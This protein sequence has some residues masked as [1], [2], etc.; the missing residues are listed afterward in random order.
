MRILFVS[1]NIKFISILVD[2]SKNRNIQLKVINY[3]EF[4]NFTDFFRYEFCIYEFK[5]ENYIDIKSKNIYVRFYDKNINIILSKDKSI[6]VGIDSFF[7]YIEYLYKLS[8]NNDLNDTEVCFYES[9]YK[10][11]WPWYE[12]KGDIISLTGFSIEEFYKNPFL[13]KEKINPVCIKDLDKRKS[14]LITRG[15]FEFYFEFIKKDGSIVNILSREIYKDLDFTKG[16]LSKVSSLKN[17]EIYLMSQ[18]KAENLFNF[19]NYNNHDLV[20]NI[21]TAYGYSS[22]ILKNIDN[23]SAI[24]D[25]VK[26]LNNIISNIS[27]VISR[28]SIFSKKEF[29]KNENINIFSLMDE[30]EPVLRSLIRNDI[31]TI[32]NIEDRTLSVFSD[33]IIIQQVLSAIAIY[34]CDI[35]KYNGQINIIASNKKKNLLNSSSMD[36]VKKDIVEIK[37]RGEL[38]FG[39]YKD[40]KDVYQ[41][42]L[43]NRNIENNNPLSLSNVRKNIEKVGGWIDIEIEDKKYLSFT[44]NLDLSLKETIKQSIYNQIKKSKVNKI[45]IVEDDDGLRKFISRILKENGYDTVTTDNIKESI[46]I[47]ERD[48]IDL[49]FSDIYLLDGNMIDWMDEIVNKKTN[50]RIIFNSGYTGENI[51]LEKIINY[52]FKFIQKPYTIKEL[53]N[54]IEEELKKI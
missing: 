16:V 22:L 5:S 23:K 38:I 32:I 36:I 3:D 7:D 21:L 6:N 2:M 17:N 10:E 26:E 13:W 25:E 35:I 40:I 33:K 24:I 19:L 46:K 11:D 27:K 20:N 41:K 37:I 18:K 43:Y 53:L 44:V 8:I 28:Y 54:I 15:V 14:Q 51:K 50:I 4:K 49:I 29:I 1:D 47:I 9:L 30:T 42:E 31:K 34:L 45:L 52:G 39:D 12:L 48:D